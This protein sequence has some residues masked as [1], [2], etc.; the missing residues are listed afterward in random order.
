MGKLIT[1]FDNSA[2]SLSPN[3]PSDVVDKIK[4]IFWIIVVHDIYMGLLTF[5]LKRMVDQFTYLR[6][7]MFKKV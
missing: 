1:N 7:R 5:S 2:I 3:I 4:I 6:N